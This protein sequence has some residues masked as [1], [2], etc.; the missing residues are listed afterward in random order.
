MHKSPP[1][2]R[3]ATQCWPSWPALAAAIQ[4]ELR[5]HTCHPVTQA[6][7]TELSVRAWRSHSRVL[8]LDAGQLSVFAALADRREHSPLTHARCSILTTPAA[9]NFS[10]VETLSR[11]SRACILLSVASKMLDWALCHLHHPPL[12][13]LRKTPWQHQP[14]QALSNVSSL[15]APR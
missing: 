3:L 5:R 14:S 2:M 9:L 6:S 12:H 4:A 13:S 8:E 7:T 11:T 15:F 10:M 1:R